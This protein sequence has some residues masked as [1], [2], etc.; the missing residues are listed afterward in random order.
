MI[1]V[2]MPGPAPGTVG[3]RFH[4]PRAGRRFRSRAGPPSAKRVVLVVRAAT[5]EGTMSPYLVD[6]IRSVPN[7]EV[8][9]RSEVVAGRGD[10]HLEELTLAEKDSGGYLRR[11]DLLDE[12]RVAPWRGTGGMRLRLNRRRRRPVRGTAH[13]PVRNQVPARSWPGGPGFPA[14]GLA[15]LNT[16]SMTAFPGK[17]GGELRRGE[18]LD[19]QAGGIEKG[20]QKVTGPTGRA[21]SED[22][23]LYAL[24][25]CALRARCLRSAPSR[26]ARRAATRA[27]PGRDRARLAAPAPPPGRGDASGRDAPARL[28]RRARRSAAAG[29]AGSPLGDA[30]NAVAACAHAAINGIRSRAAERYL[31]PGAVL[32]VAAMGEG[33]FGTGTTAAPGAW[34]RLQPAGEGA[35]APGLNHK[36]GPE[37]A[38]VSAPPHPQPRGPGRLPRSRCHQPGGHE[39]VDCILTRIQQSAEEQRPGVVGGL[40]QAGDDERLPDSQCRRLALGSQP[41]LEPA[42]D[43]T[44]A[45]TSGSPGG[46]GPATRAAGRC[47]CTRSRTAGW[48]GAG[49]PSILDAVEASH[50]TTA[51]RSASVMPAASR[52]RRTS[53]PKNA[54][55]RRP[56][57]DPAW[58]A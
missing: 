47:R 9:Y 56:G 18:V 57:P 43:G 1:L 36:T 41:V 20:Y 34:I 21:H 50:G 53:A 25:G 10:G 3:L 4:V 38:L 26:R 32:A 49:R 7:I 13:R 6:R 14:H 29:T 39:L 52:A 5:L 44:V 35:P 8:R 40:E 51:P 11:P 15:G 54:T 55:A 17:T 23:P 30:L 31:Q 22:E 37:R 24:R 16:L 45:P 46:I 58:R 33:P 42:G 2:G 28:R 48:G 19:R 12:Q 27:R